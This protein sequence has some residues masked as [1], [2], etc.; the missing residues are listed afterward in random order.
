MPTPEK[1]RSRVARIALALSTLAAA[2]AAL[3]GCA[4]G[5]NRESA[6][7][8]VSASPPAQVAIESGFL[9]DYKRL[10]PSEQFASVQMY[11]DD[12]N[13][14]KGFRKLLFQPVQV[15]R[16]A[17]RL[18]DDIPQSDLHYIAD[19]LYRSMVRRL[20]DDFELV[21]K[22]G[23]DVLEISMALTLVLKPKEKV[24]FVAADVPVPRQLTRG[25][26][27]GE[28]TRN[29]VHDCA[30]EIEFAELQPVTS[31]TS[32]GKPSKAKRIVRAAFFDN[33]RGG[34]TP[35]GDV[36]TWA[37]LDAVF[38]K[39]SEGLD[40]QLVALKDGTFKPKLT[41]GGVSGPAP[42]R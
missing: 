35:K 6:A 5:G 11:R 30:L 16:G 21:N 26:S 10:K 7:A 20:G 36:K 23:P 18:L 1:F 25:A 9:P 39:W 3:S 33:R 34:E 41:V 32:A 8:A 42:S 28:A 14:E 24:D 37:D 4:T 38:E 2:G 27:M 15:W 29:F 13:L 40:D 19:A 12:A 17:D 22:P 31:K